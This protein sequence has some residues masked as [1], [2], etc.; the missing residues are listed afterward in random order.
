[1]GLYLFT[2][3]D[4]ATGLT[5]RHKAVSHSEI[6]AAQVGDGEGVVSGHVVGRVVDGEIVPLAHEE[7]SR[8]SKGHGG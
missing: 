5:K 1:M 2:T 8:P 6:V 3:Y 7:N 4:L